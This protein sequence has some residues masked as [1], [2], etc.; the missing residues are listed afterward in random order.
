[1]FTLFL[2]ISTAFSL[3]CAVGYYSFNGGCKK[4]DEHCKE[5]KC[6]T[7]EGCSECE[8]NYYLHPTEHYCVECIG[9][10]N[11][12]CTVDGY[13]EECS[14]GYFN[15]NGKCVL[16]EHCKTFAGQNGCEE[17]ED[18]YYGATC[19]ECPIDCLQCDKKKGCT[20]CEGE[21]DVIE[22]CSKCDTNCESGNCLADGKCAKC[23]ENYY[24]KNEYCESCGK[25]CT[26]CENNKGCT[27]CDLTK[28]ALVNNECIEKDEKCLKYD[29]EN[30]TGCTLCQDDYVIYQGKCVPPYR[31]TD[32]ISGVKCTKCGG[33]Y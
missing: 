18:G 3:Q 33:W 16:V 6:Y 19:K 14:E 22:D 2:L 4:C 11:G 8:T 15:D 12:K 21:F 30:Q 26:K 32:Y 23:K 9:C 13:C 31:C 10:N 25:G 27:E 5:N 17:C 24:L 20:K 1:M 29:E 28:Y 7:E